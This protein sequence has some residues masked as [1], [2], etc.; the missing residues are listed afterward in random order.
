MPVDLLNRILKDGYVSPGEKVIMG[1]SGGVDSVSLSHILSR[2]PKLE[3]HLAH[4]NYGLRG[5]ASDHDQKLCEHLSSELSARIHICD[6]RDSRPESGVQEWARDI[7]YRF[8]EDLCESLGIE[9]VVVAHNSDDQVETVLHNLFRG[10]G[11]KGL[12]GMTPVRKLGDRI[13]VV[14]PLLDVSR[15]EILAYAQSRQ[16]SWNED[17]SNLDSDKYTRSWIRAHVVPMVESRYGEGFKGRVSNTAKQLQHLE[18]ELLDPAIAN[19]KIRLCKKIDENTISVEIEGLKASSI[20]LSKALLLSCI[21]DLDSEAK[22]DSILVDRLL[23]LTEKQKGKSVE[24]GSIV[25]YNEGDH[26]LLRIRDQTIG[27]QTAT[28]LLHIGRD[29]VVGDFILCVKIV[30]HGNYDLGETAREFVDFNKVKMPLTVRPWK[31][32]DRFSPLG[33]GGSKLVSDYL[34][35]RKLEHHRRRNQIVVLSGT[36]IV[37]IPGYGISDNFKLDSA[38]ELA[39]LLECNPS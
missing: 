7:R 34:T 26:L 31:N 6:A 30:D 27:S 13:K 23:S 29:L 9:K 3:L 39:I 1:V 16:L 19:L 11:M 32:G 12:R 36:E 37:W 10:T 5:V 28:N 8:F 21:S 24:H 35:D 18:S 14:R 4:V 22:L 15:E 20:Y 2:V 33:L 25:I 17:K 38:S